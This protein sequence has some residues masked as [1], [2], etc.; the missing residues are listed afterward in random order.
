VAARVRTGGLILNR[1]DDSKNARTSASAV[2][3]KSIWT[4]QA[5]QW[6]RLCVTAI[7]SLG[8]LIDYVVVFRA[9]GRVRDPSLLI[10]DAN[11]FHARLAG[12]RLHRAVQPFTIVSEHVIRCAVLDDIAHALRAEKRVLFEML[13]MQPN[14]EVAKQRKYGRHRRQKQQDELRA[15][16]PAA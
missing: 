14:V 1:T 2:D 12:H 8:S 5:R 16:T 6:L 9:V 7:A 11:F 3:P 4:F 15:Q 10:E 13:S